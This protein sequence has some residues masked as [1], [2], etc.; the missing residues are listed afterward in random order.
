MFLKMFSF[1]HYRLG[2]SFML[3]AF[4]TMGD[5]QEYYSVF[6]YSSNFTQAL[7][8]YTF[9]RNHSNKGSHHGSS[10]VCSLRTLSF[11]KVFLACVRCLLTNK[12]LCKSYEA[13]QE[14]ISVMGSVNSTEV[15]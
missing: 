8:Q 11:L 3:C 15:I 5:I 9:Q 12:S 4:K 13:V 1:Q 10:D 6:K 7:L 14:I 2:L